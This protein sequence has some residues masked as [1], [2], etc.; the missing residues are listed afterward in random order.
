MSYTKVHVNQA[1][2][3][4]TVYIADDDDLKR[5]LIAS[6]MSAIARRLPVIS[7]TYQFFDTGQALMRAVHA[8]VPDIVI[9]DY[10]MPDGDGLWV[11][12][13]ILRVD[14]EMPLL[15]VS[16]TP[17]D[18]FWPEVA[19]RGFNPC[20]EMIPYVYFLELPVLRVTIEQMLT[21]VLWKR[22]ENPSNLF[23]NTA[24]V[25]ENCGQHDPQ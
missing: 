25:Q 19:A 13:E 5:R 23:S 2:V 20:P 14:V 22:F 8:V 10:H 24:L 17:W 4:V 18:L 9:T 15:I 16:G 3:I 11:Y 12:G 1:P 7:V 21:D 6:L